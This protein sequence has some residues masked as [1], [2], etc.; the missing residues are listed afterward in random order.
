M[1]N[2]ENLVVDADRREF[3]QVAAKVAIVLP[4]LWSSSTIL[5]TPD[6]A[7]STI[8]ALA[9]GKPLKKGLITLTVPSV[10]DNGA[11]VKIEVKVD[12]PMTATDHVKEIHIISD[13][14]PFPET[15]SFTLGADA[16]KAELSFYS[17]MAKTQNTYAVARM[18]DGSIQMAKQHSAVTA[19]GCN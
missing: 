15:I 11:R 6:E 13:G 2:E 12:S 7:K 17:R 5:A 16:G 3:F 10:V 14:N 4:W 18:S 19:G 9:G 8:K 1:K